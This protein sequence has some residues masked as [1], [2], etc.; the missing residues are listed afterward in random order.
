MTRHHDDDRFDR[1]MRELHRESLAHLRPD[2]LR[3]LRTARAAAAEAP[4]RRIG[5]PLASAA[6][7]LFAL[8]IALPLLRPPPASSP[9]D[10]R[11][12]QPVVTRTA[13][14]AT[15]TAAISSDDVPAMLAALE[16]SPDFY[17]WLA[18]NDAGPDVLE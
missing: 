12:A 11:N 13:S 7:A 8:A 4:A 18:S 3:R 14:V 6:A 15:P 2:T 17:L 10:E 1:A 9:S 16:E 5:W